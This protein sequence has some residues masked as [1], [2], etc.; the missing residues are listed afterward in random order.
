MTTACL[1][2]GYTESNLM[3]TSHFTIDLLKIGVLATV[4]LITFYP[5]NSLLIGLYWGGGGGVKLLLRL[6]IEAFGSLN[7]VFCV[8]MNWEN[9]CSSRR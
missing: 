7:I 5:S 6:Y 4:H 1:S 3:L 9:I 2:P 8:C